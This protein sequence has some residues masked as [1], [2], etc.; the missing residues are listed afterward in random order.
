MVSGLS[1]TLTVMVYAVPPRARKTNA[2]GATFIGSRRRT[3][4]VAVI[5]HSRAGLAGEIVIS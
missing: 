5:N 1:P 4:K 2:T 3:L